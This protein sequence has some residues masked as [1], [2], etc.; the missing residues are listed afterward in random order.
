LSAE[1]TFA[2]PMDMT[3]INARHGGALGGAL[4]L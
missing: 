3:E 2:L 1:Q 4:C